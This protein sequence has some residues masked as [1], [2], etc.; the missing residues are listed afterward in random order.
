MSDATR[1]SFVHGRTDKQPPDAGLR[2][3]SFVIP[4]KDEEESLPLV[5]WRIAEVCAASGLS[6]SEIVLVDDGSRDRT[7]EVMSQLAADND[8]VQAIRL[9][10]NFGKATALMVGIAACTGDVVITMD[11]D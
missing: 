11:A 10:R 1:K 2:T 7:W 5:V 3:L 8:R 4:A 6:L 9:R